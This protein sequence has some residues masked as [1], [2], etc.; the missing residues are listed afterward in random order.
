MKD[1][2]PNLK[3]FIET[4]K[5][6]IL[7]QKEISLSHKGTEELRGE[8]GLPEREMYERKSDVE[9]NNE[10]DR[11]IKKGF[12]VPRLIDNILSGRKQATDLDYVLLSKYA[13]ELDGKLNELDINSP[14][15]DK[16][17]QQQKDALTA[18]EKTGSETAAALGIR[19]RVKVV[20]EESLSDYF[21]RELE[22]N[23]DVPLTEKQKQTVKNE[24]DGIKK[25]EKELKEKITQERDET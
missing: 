15:F 21:I 8:Y 10:A 4:N 5:D 24:F 25:A 7:R 22:L 14:E 3:N 16:I 19:G 12:N 23:N 9:L 13:A 17:L 18:A 11:L 2:L 6:D 1:K 20:K